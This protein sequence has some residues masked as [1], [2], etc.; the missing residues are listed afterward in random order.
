MPADWKPAKRRQKDMDAR[1]TKQHG[2]SYFGYKVSQLRR[3]H[4]RSA[5]AASY[6]CPGPAAK[7]GTGRCDCFRTFDS[8]ILC[9]AALP[10]AIEEKLDAARCGIGRSKSHLGVHGDSARVIHRAGDFVPDR[11]RGLLMPSRRPRHSFFD[12]C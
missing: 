5:A 4:K 8:S 11:L 1:W 2:R 10:I 9:A 7:P 12:L 6:C 3:T